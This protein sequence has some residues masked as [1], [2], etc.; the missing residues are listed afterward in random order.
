MLT[1]V[2]CFVK[3]TMKTKIRL[4]FLLDMSERTYKLDECAYAINKKNTHVS[5]N[6]DYSKTCL[7]RPL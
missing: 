5:P 3:M 2:L 6:N 7:K 1:F 4:L